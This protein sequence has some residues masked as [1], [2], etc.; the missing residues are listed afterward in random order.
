MV[1][2]STI[3]LTM[4]YVLSLVDCKTT[5]ASWETGPEDFPRANLKHVVS[6]TNNA[7]DGGTLHTTVIKFSTRVMVYA[8]NSPKTFRLYLKMDGG[9]FQG[10]EVL[11][12]RFAWD[13][14]FKEFAYSNLQHPWPPPNEPS[15][16]PFVAVDA[17]RVTVSDGV[18]E[19]QRI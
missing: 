19:V 17:I 4:I 1:R 12:A 3:V 2:Y 18:N 14:L 7:L 15:G 13:Q 8:G 16:M 6:N 9:W 11:V 10:D 5:L